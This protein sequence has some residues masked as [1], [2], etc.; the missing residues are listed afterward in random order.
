MLEQL[1]CGYWYKPVI[2]N[3]NI[4]FDFYFLKHLDYAKHLNEKLS[5]NYQ[6]R[7]ILKM[8]EYGYIYN[9]DPDNLVY[10]VGLEDFGHGIFRIESRLFVHP[11]YRQKIWKSP[12]SY[13]VI[14]KQINTNNTSCNF[15]FKSRI[16]RN[17]AGFL[18]SAKLDDYFKSWK[19]YPSM[20][21]L[22]YK[23]NW[24]W[25]M[26]K[27]VRNDDEGKYIEKICYKI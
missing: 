17:P 16:A 11:N 9:K 15:L 5:Q 12:D 8:K 20:I 3:N 1:E 6:I 19:V 4:D 14:K 13:E 18:I 2:K 7:H 26:Y 23:E 25:I 21:E 10:M 22:K 27:N 24:Q